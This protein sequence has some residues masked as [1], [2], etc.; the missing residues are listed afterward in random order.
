MTDIP[1]DPLLERLRAADPAARSGVPAIPSREQVVAARRRRSASRSRRLG[2]TGALTALAAALAFALAP[3][4]GPSDH[5]FLLRAAN[6]AALPA[7]AIVVLDSE[8]IARG[9]Q[10]FDQRR[11]F[12]LLTSRTGRI[13]RFRTLVRRTTGTDIP[14]PVGTEETGFS[15]RPG[16][17]RSY[18]PVTRRVRVT[19]PVTVEPTTLFASEVP[20]LLAVARKMR[21]AHIVRRNGLVAYFARAVERSSRRTHIAGGSVRSTH[22]V[23]LNPETYAPYF[24]RTTEVYGNGA[25]HDVAERMISRR[26]LP[27]TPA[28]RRFLRL[29]GPTR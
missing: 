1:H 5:G 19:R 7:N 24:D 4:G 8:L 3:G 17:L 11:T 10:R 16:R 15:D 25:V 14:A 21:G 9:D 12:W 2:A 22:E 29:R 28:N 27:D 26:T 13:I 18:D 6:A 23:L 20:K